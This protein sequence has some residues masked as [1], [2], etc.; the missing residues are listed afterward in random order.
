M[1][2][3]VTAYNGP[4]FFWAWRQKK[5]FGASSIRLAGSAHVRALRKFTTAH[6]V[7]PPDEKKRFHTPPACSSS[8]TSTTIS[9]HISQDDQAH[10][11]GRRDVRIKYTGQRSN[12]T[13]A[14]NSIAA[15]TALGKSKQSLPP[16]ATTRCERNN[17]RYGDIAKFVWSRLRANKERRGSHVQ[18]LTW[19]TSKKANQLASS[20]AKSRPMKRHRLS[21]CGRRASIHDKRITRS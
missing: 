6:L 12:C 19:D 16:L 8:S 21:R 10:K 17:A 7:A 20:H 13:K 4:P 15:S 1:Q 11:E 18:I 14:N 5:T 2:I 9:S 3:H